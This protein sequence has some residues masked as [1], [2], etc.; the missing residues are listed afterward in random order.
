MD[1]PLKEIEVIMKD[2]V[3]KGRECWLQW[4]CAGCG[5]RLTAKSSNTIP[6]P[7]SD[8]CHHAL[9]EAGKICGTTYIGDEFGLVCRGPG[10]MEEVVSQLG[11]GVKQFL[12]KGMN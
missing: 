10:L 4:T 8:A 12:N 6:E 3:A 7:K 9:T 5:E 1:K 2:Q 11:F